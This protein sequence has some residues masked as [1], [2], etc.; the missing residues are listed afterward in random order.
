MFPEDRQNNQSPLSRP[1]LLIAGTQK[2]GTTVLAAYLSMHPNISMSAKKE[3]HFFDKNQL[4]NRGIDEYLSHFDVGS[5]TTAL[6]GEATPFYIASRMA[7]ARI[8]QHFP[9]AKLIVLLRE[10][11]AR[12]YSEYQMKARRC[13]ASDE[14]VQLLVRNSDTVWNC[15]MQ[16]PEDYEGV[17]RCLPEVIS[18]HGRYG[19]L[20]KAI[21]NSMSKWDDWTKTVRSCFFFTE[22]SLSLPTTRF[23]NQSFVSP[24]GSLV[25]EVN[26]YFNS[27]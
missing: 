20:T 1:L 6:F 25:V 7:C 13:E 16:H 3:L 19:K 14:F 24:P 8:H 26:S 12:A 23:A 4:Y 5:E 2:S 9:T 27:D 11:V 21:K 17:K 18:T 22:S 15:L 10:P